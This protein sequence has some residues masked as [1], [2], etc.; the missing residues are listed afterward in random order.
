M[1]LER[2]YVIAR[3]FHKYRNDPDFSEIIIAMELK[4]RKYWEDLSI[5]FPLACVMDP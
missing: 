3:T 2:L 1:V 5:L 4:F